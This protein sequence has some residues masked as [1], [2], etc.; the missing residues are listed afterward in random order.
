MFKFLNMSQGVKS[1]VRLVPPVMFF[2][3]LLQITTRIK[4]WEKCLKVYPFW[5]WCKIKFWFYCNKVK[6]F[7]RLKQVINF[8]AKLQ[9]VRHS[10]YKI[11]ISTFS[12]PS[13]PLNWLLALFPLSFHDFYVSI[14]SKI[15]SRVIKLPSNIP[16]NP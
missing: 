13:P 14:F 9:N 1:S 16:L 10:N 7:Q 15:C 6:Q 4:T 12:F 5:I 11:I 3:V 8:R 2:I